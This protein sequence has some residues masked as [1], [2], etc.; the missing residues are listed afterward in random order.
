MKN[1]STADYRA[2]TLLEQR[3]D[4]V[5]KPADKGSSTIIL[6][7]SDYIFEA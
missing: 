7:K 1:M 6:N 4:I 2:L 5:F 3:N